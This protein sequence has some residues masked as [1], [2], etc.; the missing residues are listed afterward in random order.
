MP[1]DAT[2]GKLRSVPRPPSVVAALDQGT[3]STRCLVFDHD[4]RVLAGAQVEHRQSFPQPGW[5]EHDA[6]EIAHNAHAVLAEAVQK[7][8]LDVTDVAAIGITNQRETTLIWDR[9]TGEPV[10][11]A[12]VWQD[13]R[14]QAICDELAGSAGTGR[15]RDRTGLPLA[16]YFAGPK[17]CW[18][19]EHGGGVRERAENGELAVGTMDSWVLWTLSGGADRPGGAVHLTDATNASRTMLMDL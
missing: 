15:Y 5:V 6:V 7:S 17:A 9:A 19:L 4:A 1:D 12:I 10:A 11:P 13:T 2:R 16:T 18:L 8:G 14:T 3:T